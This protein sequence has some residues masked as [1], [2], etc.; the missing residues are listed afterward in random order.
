VNH[1]QGRVSCPY[2]QN[3]NATESDTPPAGQT[4][5][6]STP[7]FACDG[8]HG[9]PNVQQS[10]C[11]LP[12]V[13]QPVLGDPDTGKTPGFSGTGS[14]TVLP[15]CADRTADKAVYCSCRCENVDGRTDDGDVYC[16]CPS[17]FSCTQL[18][19][20]IGAGNAGLTGGYC[21]KN[22][23]AFDVATSC[24]SPCSALATPGQAS[25]CGPS[26]SAQL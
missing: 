7:T 24:E 15:N 18:V 8:E 12:G 21:I 5:P 14:S 22:N 4:T 16:S 1:F 26:N 3:A 23:T 2:G 10:P 13:D 9:A 6:P 19:T 11:C 17:G 25:Y 20:P